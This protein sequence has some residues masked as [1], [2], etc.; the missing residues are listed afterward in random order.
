MRFRQRLRL[1]NLP[2]L[3]SDIPAL[4][5]D[6]LGGKNGVL[7]PVNLVAVPRRVVHRV[8]EPNA[9]GAVRVVGRTTAPAAI[10]PLL[11]Y[12]PKIGAGMAG[13]SLPHRQMDA[14]PLG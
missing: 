13:R 7:A 8:C 1:I 6:H 10:T 14:R 12:S 3:S 9:G 11:P 4:V 5:D 2:S